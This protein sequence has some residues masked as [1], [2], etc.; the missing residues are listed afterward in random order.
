MVRPELALPNQSLRTR[1]LNLAEIICRQEVGSLKPWGGA[2]SVFRWTPNR[3]ESF[4]EPITLSRVALTH[5]PTQTDKF[6][7]VE[8]EFGIF[9]DEEMTF[10]V[11]RQMA[12][13]DFPDDDWNNMVYERFAASYENHEHATCIADVATQTANHDTN[14]PVFKIVD[15]RVR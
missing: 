15:K 13:A 4:L 2:G 7:V 8:S 11:S 14:S 1:F 10:V 9:G 3:L 12:E 6:K 5:S